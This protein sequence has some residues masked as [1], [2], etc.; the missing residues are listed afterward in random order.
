MKDGLLCIPE[1]ELFRD[2]P[3]AQEFFMSLGLK[4]L[5]GHLTTPQVVDEL[6]DDSSEDCG[7]DRREVLE[8]VVSASAGFHHQKASWVTTG[9]M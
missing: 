9:Y 4:E 8:H 5:S 3:H 6:P 7:L 2:Y 1:N